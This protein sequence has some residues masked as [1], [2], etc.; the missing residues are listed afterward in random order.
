MGLF[1]PFR[2][3]GHQ[4]LRQV[5]LVCNISDPQ[6]LALQ[7]REPRL[8]VVHPGTRHGWEMNDQA[9]VLGQPGVHLL[10][11]VHLYMSKPHVKSRDAQGNLPIELFQKDHAFRLPFAFGSGGIHRS[12]TGITTGQQV[13]RSRPRRC[14]FDPYRLAR[15]RG[16]RGCLAGPWLEIGFLVHPQ[17]HFSGAQ[18][19]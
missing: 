3:N 2:D 14:M 13:Q 12:R 18:G 1:I 5:L 16:P 19:A 8:D 7:H 10:A 9:W 17:P 11:L 6:A 4:P 15:W